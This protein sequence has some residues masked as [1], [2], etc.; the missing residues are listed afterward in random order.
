MSLLSNSIFSS[1]LVIGICMH[2]KGDSADLITS[3]SQV[4]S[5]APVCQL[6][7]DAH[8]KRGFNLLGVRSIESGDK[9]MDVLNYGQSPDITP[10]WRLAQWGTKHSLEGTKHHTIGS[11]IF[12]YT[13]G[14]KTITA[15]TA[16]GELVLGARA[17]QEYTRPRKEGE[18]WPHL[19]IE[20]YF[21]QKPYVKKLQALRVKLKVQ[22]TSYEA[23]MSENEYD[24]GLHAAQLQLYLM[25]Q[26]RDTSSSKFG[27]YFWFGL[28]PFDN[29]EELSKE[30]WH[31]DGGKKDTTH[32]FIY[33]MPA[34]AFLD[35]SLRD[36][37]WATIDVDVL[38]YI[39]KAQGLAYTGGFLVGT[40]PEQLALTGMNF[41]WELPGTFDVE[42]KIQ[43]LEIMAINTPCL[44]K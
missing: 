33:I 12:S 13:N 2:R 39:L 29:R 16:R 14:S 10:Y 30:T 36:G 6:L 18:E 44:N 20:Q 8:F 34:N 3:I 7:S 11:R 43:D 40:E 4:T 27:D 21:S 41:G 9:V 25:V 28:A 19:L 24:P 37:T 5:V 22:L 23:C 31:K 42:A 1:A 32:K 15:D 35:R 26:N 38:P 17:S